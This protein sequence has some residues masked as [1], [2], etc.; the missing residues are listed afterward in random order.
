MLWKSFPEE[1]DLP[2]KELENGGSDGP[3]IEEIDAQISMGR[4][5]SVSQR[6]KVQKV[7]HEYKRGK[8]KSSS[9][10]RVTNRNQALAIALSEARRIGK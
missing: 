3:K 9:G 8:L 10:R 2:A 4:K 7:M 1:T 6:R 5:M